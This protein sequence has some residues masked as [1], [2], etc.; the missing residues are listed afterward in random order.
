MYYNLKERCPPL[1]SKAKAR[2]TTLPQEVCKHFSS[3][4][5]DLGGKLCV[6]MQG[7]LIKCRY[8]T[9]QRY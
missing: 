7:L 5:F 2:V 6:D 4:R 9:N 1:L 3:I 8:Q